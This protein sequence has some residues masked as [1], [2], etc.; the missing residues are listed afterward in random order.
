MNRIKFQK[1]ATIV[2]VATLLMMGTSTAFSAA[3]N[4]VRVWVQY[5]PGHSAATQALLQRAGAHFHY[6]F[7]DLESFVVTMPENAL[8]GIANSPYVIGIEEDALRYPVWDV[9]AVGHFS[10]M[11]SPQ[12]DIPENG[13][14]IP[15]GIDAVQ[16]RDVWGSATGA[17]R[18]VCIID[19]GYYRDHE[20]LPDTTGRVD[21]YSQVDDDWTRDGHGHGTHVAGTI[22]ALN[23]DTGVVGVIPGNVSLYIIK[24]FNDDGYWTRASDLV[25][26]IYRCADNGSN[27]ISMSLSGTRPNGA[28]KR[29][30]NNLYSQGVLSIAAASNEAGTDYHY[31]ASYDSVVSVAAID[32]T[33]M[34]ADF[35][36]QNDQVELSGPGVS[37][38]S[39]I[40]FIEN[41]SLTVNGVEYQANHIEYSARGETSG[42]LVYGGLCDSTGNWSDKVVL[43]QRGEISFYEKVMNVQDSEGVAAVIYN[44]V[45]GNFFGTLGDGN[46]SDIIAISLSQQDGIYLV[47]N[48]IGATG[49][50]TSEYTW[51]AN[52]YQS[53]DGTSMATPHVSAVAAL[54]WSYKPAW[55]NLQIREALQATALDLGVSGRDVAYGFGLVQAADALG[56]LIDGGGGPPD[57]ITLTVFTRTAG[58]NWFADLYWAGATSDSID[59]FRD[60]DLI[61]TIDNDGAYTDKLGR[62]TGTFTYQV[63]EADKNDCSNEV[64]ITVE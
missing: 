39:T 11:M 19:T 55:T 53:W 9:S 36:Q 16:A 60:G 31:P 25:D 27:V 58:P 37:V 57:D 51:P 23:N 6:D 38:L 32:E 14:T 63:C 64:Q 3:K 35:S 34:V 2:I 44:N 26:A 22:A 7:E 15:W 12:F 43:C 18:T 54:I 40:P 45:E 42:E 62:V 59:I 13:Q 47:A 4:P 28:E 41:N 17:G 48:Q 33:L 46:T 5:H 30:F 50:V 8:K 29:A 49:T 20:D 52:G 61:D 10:S 1:I 24:I 56:Y 21:G